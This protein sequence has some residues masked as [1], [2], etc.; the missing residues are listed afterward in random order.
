MTHGGYGG[1]QPDPFGPDPVGGPPSTQGYLP[2]LTPGAPPTTGPVFP[3]PGR[4]AGEVN[5]FATLSIVFAFVFAP[6]GAVLGHVALS[7]IKRRGQRGRE[8]AIIGLT[9]SYV[10]IVLAVIALVIWLLMSDASKP[11][12]SP[13]PT[14]ATTTPRASPPPPRTT[15]FTPPP[16]QRPTVRVEQLRVGDCVEVQQTQPDPTKGPDTN[17]ILI[18]PVR[19]EVRDGVFRVDQ[20]LTTSACPGQ[21]LFDRGETVF[22]CI[23]D[24]RG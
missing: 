1:G 11:P 16:A 15:V 9:I 6:V 19:C 2:P 5:T 20:I 18:F 17:V 12:S 3:A 23:S 10:L 13:G 22:A 7:Q 14:T 21:T 4:P 24:Y 8:R